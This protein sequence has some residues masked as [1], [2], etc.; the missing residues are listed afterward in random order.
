ME[1]LEKKSF[2]KP[3]RREGFRMVRQDPGG[4]QSR[5][6]Y[7]HTD[8][9]EVFLKRLPMAC[10]SGGVRKDESALKRIRKKSRR[11]GRHHTVLIHPVLQ[12]DQS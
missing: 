4:E 5:E 7:F 9:G 3:L 1:K 2:Q 12:P 11:T 6:I 10:M 8:T